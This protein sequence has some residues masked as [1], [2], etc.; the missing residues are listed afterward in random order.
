MYPY[1]NLLWWKRANFDI[2]FR[3]TAC[4]KQPSRAVLAFK[5]E[6]RNSRR[7]IYVD[8]NTLHRYEYECGYRSTV[9]RRS[10]LSK[11]LG[12]VLWPSKSQI[13]SLKDFILYV[14]VSN[15]F[16]I[17][18]QLELRSKLSL[19]VSTFHRP[20]WGETRMTMS[21]T[22]A[23]SITVSLLWRF[24]SLFSILIVRLYRQA[25]WRI[26]KGEN[27][28]NGL[29]T[30]RLRTMRARPLLFAKSID[31]IRLSSFGHFWKTITTRES[32]ETWHYIII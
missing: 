26:L 29:L 1:R 21:I 18:F 4:T 15:G 6:N 5:T 2:I 13:S 22:I 17:V 27:G 16:S 8:T 28:A 10:N 24:F 30:L 23:I 20:F 19:L 12:L 7:R 9:R 25:A 31:R 11:I 3:D 14:R 32:S